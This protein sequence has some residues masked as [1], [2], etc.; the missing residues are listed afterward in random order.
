MK[1]DKLRRQKNNRL[2]IYYTVAPSSNAFSYRKQKTKNKGDEFA[3]KI[4]LSRL[5]Y[6]K[7]L[8][9]HDFLF[10]IIHLSNWRISGAQTAHFLKFILSLGLTISFAIYIH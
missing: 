9:F 2:T 5:N 1:K 6:F 4:Q 3:W 10:N 7:S 8:L